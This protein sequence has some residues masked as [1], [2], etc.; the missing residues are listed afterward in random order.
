MN[1]K[2]KNSVTVYW[3]SS[4][5]FYLMGESEEHKHAFFPAEARSLIK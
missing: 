4:I 3:L 5:D 2:H 1:G